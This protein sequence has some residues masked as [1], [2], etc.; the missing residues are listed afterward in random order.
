[1]EAIRNCIMTVI[2]SKNYNAE[3][4]E[5]KIETLW[6]N[7]KLTDDECSEL[8]AAAYE[9]A[10]EVSTVEQQILTRLSAI[11]QKFNALES[12]IYA[13]EHNGEEEPEPEG[14]TYAVY[15]PGYVTSK[16]ETVMFDYN[17]D[18][19][20]DYLRYDGGKAQTAL[21]PGKI[22]GWHVVDAEG[23]ILGT[24]YKGEFT[25]VEPEPETPEEPSDES[26]PEGE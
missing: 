3:Q 13:L 16:G 7:G 17:N 18:G 2:N 21:S 22:S 6:I 11:E 4:L 23:N 5:I 8:I 12:R 24:Y 25:P 14:P 10:R 26:A 15:E 9:N 20:L 19:E 1:M